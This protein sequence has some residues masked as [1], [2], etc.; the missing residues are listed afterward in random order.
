MWRSTNS[1]NGGPQKT[2]PSANGNGNGVAV[3]H[4]E[5]LDVLRPVGSGERGLSPRKSSLVLIPAHNEGMNLPQVLERVHAVLPGVDVLVI[6]DGS[7]DDT[8]KVAA[9]H[10]AIVARHPFNLGVGA[11]LQTGYRYALEHG[12]ERL[13]QLDAD[14]QHR[15]ED[16]IRLLEILRADEADMAVGC[17]FLKGSGPY[18]MPWLRRMGRDY[19]CTIIKMLTGRRFADPT[20]G[21]RAMNRHVLAL[22]A[23]DVFPADYP[24][25]D[26]LVMLCKA[27]VR[28]KEAPATMR[29][30][31]FGVSQHDGPKVVYYLFRMTL[32]LLVIA[33]GRGFKPLARLEKRDIPEL[34]AEPQ[35][36]GVAKRAVQ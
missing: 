22:F 18:P 34:V 30:R 32:S 15:P 28:I 9:E 24:D 35:P 10:G 11:A 7:H 21:L 17:R 20:S 16:V 3:K 26:V 25:A 1:V 6:D 27:G 31:E 14:G 36:V 13:V 29:L 33:L 12:Y 23:Q 2:V 8:F 5:T 19:Q 4:S